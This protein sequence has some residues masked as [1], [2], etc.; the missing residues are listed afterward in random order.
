[1]SDIAGDS[2]GGFELRLLEELELLVEAPSPAVPPARRRWLPRS[3]L[4]LV[5]VVVALVVGATATSIGAW[6]LIA[7]DARKATI[8]STL[9]RGGHVARWSRRAATGRST[10]TAVV[11]DGQTRR[12]SVEGRRDG[13]APSSA[14]IRSS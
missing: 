10:R 1:M 9:Q 8:V 12:L 6:R 11:V 4:A 7:Q 13:R 14:G 2:I 5:L 3:R